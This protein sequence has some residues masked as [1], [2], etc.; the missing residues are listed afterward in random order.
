MVR[1][2]MPNPSARPHEV[3]KEP[4]PVDFFISRRGAE[5]T[6]A[7]EVANVLLEAGYT[8]LVQDFDIPYTAN[9][10]TAIH[11]ALKRGRNLIVLLT[12]DYDQSDFTLTEVSNFLASA[13]RAS[14]ERR[15]IVL[16]VDDCEPEG[17]FAGVVYADLFGLNDPEERRQRIIAAAQGQSMASPRNARF[18]GTEFGRGSDERYRDIV[19]KLGRVV[20]ASKFAGKIEAFLEEYLVTEVGNGRVPFAGRDDEIRLLDEWLADEKAATR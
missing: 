15:L 13:A 5:A 19:L 16:R 1:L 4:P 9:F 17:I 10:V 18:S 11:W 20:A 14:D 6:I 2:S 12:R 8:V 3:A 7:Q